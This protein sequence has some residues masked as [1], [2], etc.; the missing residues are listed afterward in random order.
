MGASPIGPE[1]S[2]RVAQY[3]CR[4][5]FLPLSHENACAKSAIMPTK[6]RVTN[7][8]LEGERDVLARFAPPSG[9]ADPDGLK[10]NNQSFTPPPSVGPAPAPR[11]RVRRWAACRGGRRRR[12][13]ASSTERARHWSCPSPR[14]FARQERERITRPSHRRTHRHLPLRAPVRCGAFGDARRIVVGD[15]GGSLRTRNVRGHPKSAGSS[16]ARV[17][18]HR[19]VV[20]SGRCGVYFSFGG[21]T[22][23]ATGRVL[24]YVPT[25]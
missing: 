2:A 1:K 5:G 7:E 8:I 14:A 11:G 12:L 10:T 16:S 21:A 25:Y 6:A 17:R 15:G 9:R 23:A 19:R 13:S 22:R 3:N 4:A 18:V 24:T 20:R